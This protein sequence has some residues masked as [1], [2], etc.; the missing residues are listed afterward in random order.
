MPYVNVPSGGA[1]ASNDSADLRLID[2]SEETPEVGKKLVEAAAKWGFLWIVASPPSDSKTNDSQP[3]SAKQY[4]FDDNT[5]D[6]IFALSAKFFKEAPLEEKKAVSIKNNRGWID[7]HVENLDPSKHKRGDF[8]QAFNLKEPI[9]GTWQ[10][11]MP[12]TLIAQEEDL[13]DF[14]RRCRNMSDRILRLIAMGLEI[15]DVN[16]LTSRHKPGSEQNARLLYYPSLPPTT[17]F[18]SEQDIRAGAHSDYGSITLLFQRPSQSGLEI[19]TPAG[20]WASVPV[21]PPNY[22]SSTLPP[23]LVNIGDLLSYWTNGLLKS[24]I[25]RVILPKPAP[26]A[27]AEANDGHQSA[28]GE[29]RYS[30]AIFV[31]PEKDVPLVPMPSP[32]IADR[33]TGFSTKGGGAIG[34]GGGSAKASDLHTLTAGEHLQNRLKATYGVAYQPEVKAGA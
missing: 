28:V 10:Q 6:N 4:E 23:I 8:K 18:D 20:T 14:H 22:H 29:D 25:H 5:V 15:P 17:D 26:G 31:D 11:P 32:L 1:P 34:H 12:A 7:M 16:W 3:A 9:A 21:F 27:R 24:T 33:T 30:I 2:V 13:K 19:L